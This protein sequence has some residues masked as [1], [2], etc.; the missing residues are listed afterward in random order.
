MAQEVESLL[1]L[2]DRDLR[3]KKLKDEIKNIPV[4][5][6][7]T[8]KHFEKKKQKLESLKLKARQIE[9]ERKDLENQV[10][11]QEQLMQKYSVQQMSTKKNDE[12]QALSH[13]I[14]RCKQE[15]SKIED[16][17]LEIME[18][19]D[20]AMEEVQAEEKVVAQHSTTID[21]KVLSLEKRKENAE[22]EVSEL[23]NEITELETR[24]DA[25]LLLKYR[26]IF[27][28]KGDRALTRVTE[29][30]ICTGCHMNVTHQT[31]VDAKGGKVVMCEDC[32][33]LIYWTRE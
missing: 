27:K 6:D 14:E 10:L 21:E 8:R 33:R 9:S 18:T 16:K 29:A 13:E 1:I 24:V 11:S 4:Q 19:Y 17:E 22:K 30:K 5:I 3:L 28:S 25:S 26:R 23:H 7:N 2:Q 12:Y 20:K 15:I 31:Y 32:G